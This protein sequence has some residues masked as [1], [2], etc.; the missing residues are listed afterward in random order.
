MK[1]R[2][3]VTWLASGA[4]ARPLCAVAQQSAIPVIAYVGIGSRVDNDDKMEASKTLEAFYRGLNEGGYVDGKDVIVEFHQ[5][6]YEQVPAILSSLVKRKVAVIIAGGTPVAVAAKAATSSIPIVFSG[7]GDP[8]KLGLV[9][10]L[11]RPGGNVTGIA[12]IGSAL[13]GKRIQVLHDLLPRAKKIA[14]LTNPE[15][16]RANALI[17]DVQTAAAVSGIAVHIVEAR[18]QREI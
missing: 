11:S 2:D 7:G 4:L 12:N 6:D 5:G 1:R 18:A 14:Y 15:F 10:S 3:F 16:P 8:V 17:D 9:A 13:E